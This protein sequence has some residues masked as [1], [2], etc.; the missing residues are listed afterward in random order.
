MN[1]AAQSSSIFGMGHWM[2]QIG[3]LTRADNKNLLCIKMISEAS[4][5]VPF[6]FLALVKVGLFFTT[7]KIKRSSSSRMRVCGFDYRTPRL[8]VFPH[9]PPDKPL[10]SLSG[11][12]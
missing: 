6:T 10:P 8:L 5:V 12:Y 3:L 11:L 2:R 1:F 9:W 4:W 7:A